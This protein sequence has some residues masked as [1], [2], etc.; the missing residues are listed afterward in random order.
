MKFTRSMLSLTPPSPSTDAS[1]I[2]TKHYHNNSYPQNQLSN[3]RPWPLQRFSPSSRW[4]LSLL[5]SVS[6]QTFI[7][8]PTV[9]SVNPK[10][11]NGFFSKLIDL[12]EALVVKL[13]HHDASHHLHYLSGNFAPLRHETPPVKDLAVH[14]FLPQCLN[15]MFLRVG[16]NPKFDPLAGYHWFDGDG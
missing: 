15:G 5:D 7:N 12:L 1:F 3:H 2:A 14:G 10:P 16:P 11:S 9:F 4:R 6:D 8:P 13:M